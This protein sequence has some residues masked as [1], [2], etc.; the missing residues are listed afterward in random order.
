VKTDWRPLTLSEI[1]A[2]EQCANAFGQPWDEITDAQRKPRTELSRHQREKQ[3]TAKATQ[4]WIGAIAA[5]EHLAKQTLDSTESYCQT[6]IDND[7]AKSKGVVITGPSPVLSD[8]TLLSF[9]HGWT[10]T[11]PNQLNSLLPSQSGSPAMK[12][13]VRSL[14]LTRDDGLATEQFC[15]ILSSAFSLVLVLGQDLD[16]IPTVQ[17]SFDPATILK[18][19][20]AIIMQIH[21][22]SPT[23]LATLT[24]QVQGFMPMPPD[25]HLVTQFSRLWLRY[26]PEPKR[27]PA[28]AKTSLKLPNWSSFAPESRDVKKA[29]SSHDVELLKAIAHEIRTPLTTIRTLARLLLK[30]STLAPD[31]RPSIEKID[32][33]CTQQIDRFSLFF[34]A[35]ELETAPQSHMLALTTMSLSDVIEHSI[36]RWQQQAG[37]LDQTLSVNMPQHMPRVVSNPAMLDQALTGLIEQ[38]TR[39]LPQGSTIHIQVTQAGH[40]LKLQMQASLPNQAHAKPMF[41]S[42]GKLLMFQPETGSLTLNLSVTK[43]LFQALGGK[44]IV[45][46][47]PMDGETLTVYLPLN[48]SVDADT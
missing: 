8:R 36:P 15:L 4:E 20:H 46:D 2:Q 11:P 32:R 38:F 13:P 25:Y 37:R 48:E 44:L 16:G 19:W 26:L 34:Q 24:Q 3:A 40:Q 33:E 18:A 39:S 10:L 7:S 28:P 31:V 17:F 29:T 23:E 45:R 12:S 47:R 6:S 42:L 41:Q 30:R 21:W 22:S 1:L 9:L 5:L 14:T 27:A 43:N 35:V